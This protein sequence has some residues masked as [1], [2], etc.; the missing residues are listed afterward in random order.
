VDDNP[1]NVKL[2]ADLLE[3]NGYNVLKAVN[4]KEAIE[5]TNKKKPDLILLDILMPGSD[6]YEI[7]KIIKSSKETQ[8]IPIVMIT[9][10][11]GKEDKIKGIEAGAEDFISKPFDK[12]ELLARVRSLLRMKMM[13]DELEYSYGKLKELET[14]KDLLTHMIVHD[15]N[16]PLMVIAGRLRVLA[17]DTQEEFT[18]KQKESLK[19]ALR[20]SKDLIRMICDLLDINKME[21]GKLKLNYEN[22]RLD[23]IM[24]ET[25]DQM[26]AIAR[27]QDKD[28]SLDV[29]EGMPDISA[30]RELI[31]RVMA[32]LID[33]AIKYT[34]PK[35]VVQVRVFYEKGD[36]KFYV[37]VKD[38]GEGIPEEYLNRIFD[39]FIQVET[40]EARAGRGLGLTFCK[41]A[42]EAH[43]GK[44]R[45]ESEPG[46]GSVFTFTLPD[47]G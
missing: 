27:D 35:S 40:V 9:A 4:G 2:A 22:F 28:L 20:A 11:N 42:V 13:H 5:I 17:M 47:K 26:R 12:D 3:L 6:G 15:M 39:K 30:D 36:N 32:N 19:A 24:K 18:E 7:C 44:I 34:P 33:N 45:A 10:L 46:K 16:N 38:P 21:E 1:L 41:M 43:G 31:R 8:F 14:M 29:I 25:V 23:D 37:Q